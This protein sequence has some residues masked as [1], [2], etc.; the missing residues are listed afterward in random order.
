MALGGKSLVLPTSYVLWKLI[1]GRLMK[2]KPVDVVYGDF[3]KVFDKVPHKWLTLTAQST[4]YWFSDGWLTGLRIG[5]TTDGKE[6]V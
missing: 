3:R 4:G 6:L 2:T 1:L 5:W